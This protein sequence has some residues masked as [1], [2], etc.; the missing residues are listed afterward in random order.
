MSESEGMVSVW[1]GVFESEDDLRTYMGT[2]DDPSPFESDFAV[3]P[4]VDAEGDFLPD[5]GGELIG[6]VMG[7]SWAESFVDDLVFDLMEQPDFDSLLMV[8]DVDA[9][10][11]T[12]GDGAKTWFVGAYPYDRD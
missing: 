7:F 4:Y 11:I 3:G 8:Y 1:A 9:S 2:T 6:A 12:P 10:D 5:G